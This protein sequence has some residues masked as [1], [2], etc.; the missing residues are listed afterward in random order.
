MGHRTTASTEEALAKSTGVSRSTARQ[1]LD[2]LS[3]E[4]LIVRQ[5]ERGT[6]VQQAKMVLRMQQFV[7]FSDEMKERGLEP[8]SR[9]V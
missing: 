6:F 1:A 9:L 8:S 7:S 5:Q 2:D 4:G 3:R